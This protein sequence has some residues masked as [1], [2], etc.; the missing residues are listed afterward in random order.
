[1]KKIS[2]KSIVLAA[3][4]LVLGAAVYLNWQFSDGGLN[5][6]SLINGNKNLGDAQLVD[7]PTTSGADETVQQEDEQFA[8]MR[9][10]RQKTR[11]E[12]ISVL[13]TVTE[14]AELST[15]EKKDAA[16]TLAEIAKNMEHEG[17]IENLVKAKGFEECMAYVNGDA[18]TVTVK[19]PQALTQSQAGQIM[20]IVQGETNISAA[21]IKIVEVS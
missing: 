6:T 12:S 2:K 14:N 21:N 19:T 8:Q 16:D 20:D 7:N 15:E 3:M 18:A 17:M 13:K 4:V 1:M 9:L 10:D 5:L 11:D